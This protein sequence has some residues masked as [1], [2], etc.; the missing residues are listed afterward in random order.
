MLLD[1]FSTFLAKS[2][3]NCKKVCP[4]CEAIMRK[5]GSLDYE[6]ASRIRRP[7]MA[8]VVERHNVVWR[9]LCGVSESA[10]MLEISPRLQEHNTTAAAVAM[11]QAELG[12]ASQVT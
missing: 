8:K 10:N 11:S 4:A 3:E 12:R 7:N 2:T 1:V 9:N 6:L 5:D